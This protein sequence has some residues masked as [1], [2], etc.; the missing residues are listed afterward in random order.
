MGSYSALGCSLPV[1]P[2]AD[3][4]SLCLSPL[5]F[6]ARLLLLSQF[7]RQKLIEQ[8]M[9][10]AKAEAAAANGVPPTTQ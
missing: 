1:R 5:L 8:A 9:A 10:A 4:L 3:F 7:I 2:P 6:L